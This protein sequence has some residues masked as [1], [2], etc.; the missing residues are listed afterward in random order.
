MDP[1]ANLK[2]QLD[3]V[4]EINDIRN[5]CFDDGTYN[6]A[7]AEEL[8]QI[9]VRLAELIEALDAWIKMGGFL[10]KLWIKKVDT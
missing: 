1:N 10:P 6:D 3:L 9:A 2:E 4:E 7:Q 5:H 8:Q